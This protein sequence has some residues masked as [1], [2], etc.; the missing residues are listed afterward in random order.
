MHVDGRWRGSVAEVRAD[1]EV[2][3]VYLGHTA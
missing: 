3:A 2:A 1:P